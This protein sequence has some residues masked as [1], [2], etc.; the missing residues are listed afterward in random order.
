MDAGSSRDEEEIA[1]EEREATETT[2]LLSNG[3]NGMP[4]KTRPVAATKDSAASSR[5]LS[6]LYAATPPEHDS[7]S[8]SGKGT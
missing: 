1:A 4:S 5:Q 7:G 2:G 6:M 3:H 8:S